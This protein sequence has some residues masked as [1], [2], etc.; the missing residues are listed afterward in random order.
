MGGL[1]IRQSS[2]HA[3]AA[4][5]SSITQ[6][7]AL[8]GAILNRTSLADSPL[9]GNSISQLAVAANRPE[10]ISTG[11]IDSSIKQANLSRAIDQA[12]FDS[13]YAHS[14]DVRSHAIVLSTSIRHAGDW[15]NVVPSPA[16]GLN[17]SDWEFCLCVKYW[18]GIP[19]ASEGSICCVCGVVT[20]HMGDH[21]VTCRGN[22]D[23]IH[24]HDSIRDV[25]FSVAQSAA[26]APRKEVSSLVPNSS[27][28][29]AD[30]YLPRWKHGL[31]AA[32][33]LTVISPVQCLTIDQAAE[34][35]GYAITS[36][37]AEERKRR[38][39]DSHCQQIEWHT[40]CPSGG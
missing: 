18:L 28:R 34:S 27:S 33:D 19:L 16:L 2:L 30:L 14:P 5:V 38:V 32:F 6:S 20:D 3:P 4:F 26:L 8:M 23:L 17:L 10:W 7:G 9:L 36:T 40:F 35:Q 11:S 12:I 29:P 31:P 37:V 13:L 15:L 24:R 39:H 25:L 22:G 21:F 1:G